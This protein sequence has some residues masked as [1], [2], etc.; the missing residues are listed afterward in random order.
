MTP[1]KEE[2]VRALTLAEFEAGYAARSGVTAQWLHEHG[3]H[4]KPCA[5][6]DESCEGWQMGHAEVQT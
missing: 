4:G 3:R 6:G 5:C 1:D 2:E